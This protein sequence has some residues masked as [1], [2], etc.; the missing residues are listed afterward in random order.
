MSYA[1]SVDDQISQGRS[2][3]FELVQSFPS[4]RNAPGAMPWN[5]LKFA[6]WATS[7]DLHYDD[8]QQQS[9]AFLLSVWTGQGGAVEPEWFNQGKYRVGNFD[10]VYALK[11]W[12]H[13]HKQAFQSWC[14]NPF[15]P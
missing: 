5:S 10:P 2:C 13:L 1:S 4:V 9:A 7:L 14:L 11:V 6:A 3:F 12:D 15:W 8:A